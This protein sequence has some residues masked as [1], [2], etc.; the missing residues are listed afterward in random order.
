MKYAALIVLCFAS[1]AWSWRDS[2]Y[3][4]ASKAHDNCIWW[5]MN[6]NRADTVVVGN[7]LNGVLVNGTTS[8]VY[9][10]FDKHAA[11][12]LSKAATQY[13]A[14]T[15]PKIWPSALHNAW[16]KYSGNPVMGGANDVQFGH[17]TTNPAGGWYW[18]GITNSTVH[19]WSS[20]D[21]K[22]WSGDIMVLTNG[23]AGAWDALI[24]VAS[25]YQQTNGDWVLFYRGNL[26][27]TMHIGKATSAD[28]TTFTKVPNGGNPGLFP[29]FGNNYDPCGV[30]F[31]TGTNYVYLNGD[32]GHGI[33]HVYYST[34]ADSTFTVGP[35]SPLLKGTWESYCADIIQCAGMYY[36]V[37]PQDTA[38]GTTLY[39]HR[40]AI[41]RSKDALFPKTATEFLGYALVNDSSY[42]A[43][44]LDTPSI[45]TADV[46]RS[47]Y[48]TQFGDTTWMMYDGQSAAILQSQN[49]ASQSW[50][51]LTY[52][53]PRVE[54]F[55]GQR[56][57]SISFWI[58]FTS[59]ADGD[60]IF[61]IGPAY[62]SATPTWLMIARTS[63]PNK[64]LSLYEQT[65][66]YHNTTQ[67]VT[68]GPSYHVIISE[69][70]ATRTVYV[71]GVSVLS[72]ADGTAR[73]DQTYIFVGA[74]FNGSVDGAMW[75]F[76]IYPH[77]LSLAQASNLYRTGSIGWSQ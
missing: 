29:Q 50:R 66:G 44:V 72:T 37:I 14:I 45:P 40:I 42:D 60:P 13:V 19:R 18:F 69:D 2:T 32:G 36:L 21:L 30:M 43:S 63:G 55:F 64:V 35:T 61:S 62:N 67:V 47:V 51:Y 23:G 4:A 6:D 10:N 5:L 56:K 46:T 75:D 16:T 70:G 34:D 53:P 17:L 54:V 20:S 27:G 65:G 12:F 68:V 9:T 49:L 8:G 22:T 41:Y 24:Q 74:G 48:A 11:F 15:V 57:V 1:L 52:L 7:E 28:G 26:S 59:L 31:V 58:R 77:D 39:N 71:N 38:A 33:S 25:C 3:M 76:R 73:T